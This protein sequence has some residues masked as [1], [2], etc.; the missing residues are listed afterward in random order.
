MDEPDSSNHYKASIEHDENYA[1]KYV[2]FPEEMAE[3]L[4]NKISLVVSDEYFE[5]DLDGINFKSI[6]VLDNFKDKEDTP[7]EIAKKIANLIGDSDGYYYIYLNYYGLKKKDELHTF[8][9]RCSQCRSLAKKPRK[10]QDSELQRDRESIE[11]FDFTEEIKNVIQDLMPSDIYRI[12]ETNHPEIT[13]KQIHAW[14]TTFI[15]K[16]FVTPFFEQFKKNKEIFVD[17]TYKTNKLGHELNSIVGQYDGAGFALAYLFVE[18]G[19]QDGARTKILADFFKILMYLGMDQL[20]CMYTERSCSDISTDNTLPQKITC[21]SYD[22]YNTFNIIDIGFYPDLPIN[23]IKA[24]NNFIFCPKNLRPQITSMMEYHMHFHP[25][26]PNLE[27]IFMT[28]GE[29]WMRC[30]KEM[31]EFCTTNS[32][33]HFWSYMWQNWYRGELWPLWARSSMPDR[34]CIFCTM[35][36]IESHWKAT[37]GPCNLCSCFTTYTTQYSNIMMVEKCLH[38]ARNLKEWN[39]LKK[40]ELR[41]TYLTNIENWFC[42]TYP[43]IALP[44]LTQKT[45]S[46]RRPLLSI[47]DNSLPSSNHASNNDNVNLLADITVVMDNENSEQ[48]FENYESILQ[49]ALLIWAKAVEKSFEG[50]STMVTDIK[51]YKQR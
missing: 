2:L 5:N 20:I 47:L 17:A 28:K 45:L 25:L 44:L 7:Q 26:I 22:A 43:F 46:I 31:Y 38:G 3:E 16:S 10:H 49:D 1:N 37:T 39:M 32:L 33:K 8:Q 41:H 11:R 27:G 36:L 40:K 6:I 51:K 4:F 48:L 23:K 24:R 30:T 9:Y 21:S 29:I 34:I 13:Q 18:G 15:K 42:N 12:L 14:W 50:I 19:R 35:M